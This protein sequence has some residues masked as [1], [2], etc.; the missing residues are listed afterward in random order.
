MPLARR[1]L[2]ALGLALAGTATVRRAAAEPD[3]TTD[4]PNR[5]IRMVVPYPPGGGNDLL[6]RAIK[7]PL[8]TRWGQLIV[9]D[10]RPGANGTIATEAVAKGP[11]DGYTLLMGSTAT[12]AINPALY[13]RLGYDAVRDFSP[14][15]MVGST[16][17][18]LTVHPSVP[19][20]SVSELIALAKAK[21]GEISFASVGNGSVGHLAGQMFQGAA[22]IE[23]LHVPYRGIAQASTELLTGLVKTAF[24]NVVNVLPFIRDGKLRPLAVTTLSRSAVLPEVPA[25]AETLPGFDIPLWWGVFAPARTPA[26][27]VTKLNGGIR[28]VLADPGLQARWAAEAITLTPDTPEAFAARIA[29]DIPRWA[30]AVRASGAEVN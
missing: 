6:A 5:P 27:V 22:G 28:D 8:E 19:A 17:L 18:I 2:M 24:S 25:I 13:H 1:S 20:H 12:H 30:E 4:F 3:Q 21:P 7:A 16:P 29:A 10:N 11:A 14:V 23:M 9:V 26:P 15:A